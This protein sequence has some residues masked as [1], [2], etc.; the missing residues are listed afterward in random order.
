[1]GMP[2]VIATDL[3]GTLFFPRRRLRMISEKSIRFIRRFIDEGNRLVLVS[4]R[5][6][7][8]CRKVQKRIGRH[9]DIVGCN[10]AYIY[11]NDDLVK[12]T[13]FDNERITQIVDEI[14]KQYN[15][16]TISIMTANKNY[17]PR[18]ENSFINITFYRLYAFFEFVYKEKFNKSLRKYREAFREGK[19]YKILFVLGITNKAKKE[20]KL[21]NKEIREK[22][23]NELESS[24]SN[25]AIELSPAG[26][27][28]AEG[29]KYYADY[30][31][32][33]RNDIYVVGD[34]GND[35]SMF[36][37]F[38]NNS[39]CMSRSSLSVSK[40]AKHIIKHFWEI[41]KHINIERK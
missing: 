32:I 34:S 9:V 4:G 37:E 40:H 10:G 1:M 14:Q 7:E 18:K 33:N 25:Q 41:E 35:I 12:E 39:F 15:P 31:M 6:I 8:Y 21:A 3:D 16:A 26:C 29:L 36:K 20:A 30:L 13:C 19:I 17:F 2:K 5:N 24:W 22:Y 28:K 23:K 11:I 27:S 38:H